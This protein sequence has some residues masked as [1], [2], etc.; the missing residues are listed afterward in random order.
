MPRPRRCVDN[1]PGARLGPAG[2]LVPEPGAA[3]EDGVDFI[4]FM[5]VGGVFHVVFYIE[6]PGATIQGVKRRAG[7]AEL[8]DRHAGRH[9]PSGHVHL[10]IG[11]PPIQI[12]TVMHY[13]IDQRAGFIRRGVR[14]VSDASLQPPAVGPL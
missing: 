14:Q 5:P 7:S 1:V 2:R 11:P 12:G 13:A 9:A 6:E 8:A 4:R 3:G 10:G